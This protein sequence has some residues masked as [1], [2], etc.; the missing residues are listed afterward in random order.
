MSP[1]DEHAILAMELKFI[2]QRRIEIIKRMQV[3][4]ELIKKQNKTSK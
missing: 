1:Q 2:E 4:E 3:N